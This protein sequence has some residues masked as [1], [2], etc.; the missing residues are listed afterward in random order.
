MSY[1]IEIRD[2]ATDRVREF[3]EPV[4]IR[5]GTFA[6]GGTSVAWFNITSN[7]GGHYAD[8]G[9]SVKDDFDGKTVAE[10][11]PLAQRAMHALGVERSGDYW[12]PTPGNA[13]AA[14]ADL[15]AMMELCGESD[16]LGVDA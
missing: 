15:L 5:G 16:V 14:M 13:G 2:P 12:E 9:F 11:R 10:V 1:D 4:D 3:P 7:Y 6:A 8:C